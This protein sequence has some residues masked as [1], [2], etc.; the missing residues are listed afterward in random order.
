MFSANNI[1]KIFMFKPLHL[2][3]ASSYSAFKWEAQMSNA[4]VFSDTFL[5]N[6]MGF[7]FACLFLLLPHGIEEKV[8]GGSA[9]WSSLRSSVDLDIYQKSSLH[10]ISSFSSGKQYFPKPTHQFNLLIYW[11]FTIGYIKKNH[12]YLKASFIQTIWVKGFFCFQV[13]K[14]LIIIHK[15]ILVL[16]PY[17]LGKILLTDLSSRLNQSIFCLI[18]LSKHSQ[19]KQSWYFESESETDSPW[20]KPIKSLYTLNSFGMHRAENLLWK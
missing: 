2:L 12:F 20:W 1:W 14:V 11:A 4:S 8:R 3:R 17:A 16:L 7:N 18:L 19:L 6:G 13:A 10:T 5:T 15:Y 9:I